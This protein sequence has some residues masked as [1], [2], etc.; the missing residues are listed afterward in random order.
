VKKLAVYAL[1]VCSL[2][3]TSCATLLK[4][5]SDEITVVSDPP[6]AEV[7]ANESKKGPT[8][9][10]FTVPSKEDLNISITKAGYQQED[11]QDPAKFRWGYEAWSFIEWVIPMVVDLSDGAAWGHEHL[12]MTAHLEPNGQP[13][14]AAEGAPPAASAAAASDVRTSPLA[15]PSPVAR[16][17]AISNAPV[18][19]TAAAPSASAA[20]QPAAFVAPP[21]PVTSAPAAAPSASAATQPA[22]SN[23]P[24]LPVSSAAPI[25]PR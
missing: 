10:S 23:A 16:T 18:P 25:T 1:A 12:T 22:A 8:P 11:L 17:E 13:N 21:L 6:G 5:T 19:P 24:L 15:S 14:P 4:G 2:L 7:T 20:T 3:G 9:V